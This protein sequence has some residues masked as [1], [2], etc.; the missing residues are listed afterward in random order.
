MSLYYAH[1]TIYSEALKIEQL[2]SGESFDTVAERVTY[3]FPTALPAG[4]KAELRIGFGGKLTG[5]MAGYYKSSWE[6]EGKT[7]FY[8]LTQFEASS[9]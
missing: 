5:G 7:K 9:W 1:R 3:S 2:Q 8:A 6:H 4:S